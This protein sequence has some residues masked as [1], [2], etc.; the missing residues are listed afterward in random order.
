MLRQIP[1]E[2]TRVANFKT[3]KLETFLMASTLE[4][5]LD[6]LPDIRY[7]AVCQRGS[8]H[9]G[10]HPNHYVAKKPDFEERRPG[11]FNCLKDTLALG[12]S[13]SGS[14]FP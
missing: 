4:R 6:E 11:A 7:M 9:I 12:I 2:A 14:Q 13:E 5:N 1:E 8:T 10:L 3:D